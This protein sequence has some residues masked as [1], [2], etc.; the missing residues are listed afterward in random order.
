MIR[1]TLRAEIAGVLYEYVV[2]LPGTAAWADTPEE[3][4]VGLLHESMD[5]L[6]RALGNA[7]TVQTDDYGNRVCYL[8]GFYHDEPGSCANGGQLSNLNPGPPEPPEYDGPTMPDDVRYP[9]AYDEPEWESCED[10]WGPELQ[11]LN[12]EPEPEP[13]P[14]SLACRE[15]LHDACDA[16]NG[17][18]CDCHDDTSVAFRD[19]GHDAGECTCS[20]SFTRN[21]GPGCPAR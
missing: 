11:A 12:D 7:P 17:C 18:V 14:F 13:Y 6:T 3:T 20:F 1:T 8:C 19:D 5:Q 15:N 2:E 16:R 4:A 10:E 21:H 9:E